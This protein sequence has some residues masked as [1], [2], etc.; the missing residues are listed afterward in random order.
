VGFGRW[1]R[2]EAQSAGW[3][4]REAQELELVAV[5]LAT[6]A[7]RHGRGGQAQLELGREWA[8]VEVVDAGPG[9]PDLVLERHRRGLRFEQVPPEPGRTGL[10]AGLDSVRRLSHRLEIT[11]L[12]PCGARA[13]AERH[14]GTRTQP[15]GR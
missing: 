11:N 13:R 1:V 12:A 9:F 5:E 10:G 2:H 4:E 6:N 14:R 3:S 8:A 15:G 7:V